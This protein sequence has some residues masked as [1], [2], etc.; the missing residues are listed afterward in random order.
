MFHDVFF[1]SNRCF[2]VRAKPE[3]ANIS[4]WR[5][6]NIFWGAAEKQRV[7]IGGFMEGVFFEISALLL[8][9]RGGASAILAPER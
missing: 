4:G 7:T 3:N 8:L 1:A 2:F 9:T 5:R 6:G